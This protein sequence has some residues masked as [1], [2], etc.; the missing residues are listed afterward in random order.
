MH[1]IHTKEVLA[2]GQILNPEN[3]EY[4]KE[5]MMSIMLCTNWVCAGAFEDHEWVSESTTTQHEEEVMGMAL[6]CEFCIPC[7]VQW[8]MLWFSAPTTL[9]GTLEKQDSKK[10][11]ST[12]KLST[13]RLR[14]HVRDHVGGEHTPRWC[15][16]AVLK[17]QHK[18]HRKPRVNKEMEGWMIERES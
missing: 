16:L 17:V 4:L 9:N 2:R 5:R 1:V 12:T 15:M 14:T 6:D 3:E 10:S 18:T 8:C 7:V 11:K 13:W